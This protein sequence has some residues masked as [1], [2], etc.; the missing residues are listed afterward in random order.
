MNQNPLASPCSAESQELRVIG[1]ESGSAAE[2]DSISPKKDAS[3]TLPSSIGRNPHRS[4]MCAAVRV[5]DAARSSVRS[6]QV[7]SFEQRAA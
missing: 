7:S 2:V 4:G 3:R 1:A 5:I 6:R